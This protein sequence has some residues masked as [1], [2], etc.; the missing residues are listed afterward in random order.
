MTAF[1][2]FKFLKCT[3][4]A[5]LYENTCCTKEMLTIQLTILTKMDGF[6]KS[7]F[8]KIHSDHTLLIRCYKDIDVRYLLHLFDAETALKSY[9]Y[10]IC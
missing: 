10:V 4:I 8:P 7:I 5:L 6:K 3:L 9:Y 1:L 2:M